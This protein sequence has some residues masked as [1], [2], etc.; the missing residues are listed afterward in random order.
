MKQI[1][2]LLTLVLSLSVT[3]QKKEKSTQLKSIDS[4]T[5][6]MVQKRGIIT[7]YLNE[8]N[9]LF[10]EMDESVLNKDLLV[11]T[12]IAQLPAN[13]SAYLNAGSKTAE[14]VLRFS[15]K[16]KKIILKQVGY[17]NIA[18]EGDPIAL[19]VA[20]NNF[21]PILAAFDIKNKE[22]DR[23]L[24]DVSSHFLADSPGFNII[25]KGDK[26]R[27][28][29]GS[30]DKKRSSI[31]S[32]NSFPKNTEVVHTLTFSVNKPPR[33]NRAKT[34]SFQINHSFIALPE[35]PMPIRYEDE[36]VGWF[37]LNKIN[38]SSDALKADDY[39]IV[40]RW[41]LEPKDKAA[42][43]AGELVEPIQP[44]VYYLD[45]ATP[46]KWRKYFKM[47]IEDWN[48][49]FAKAGFKNAI[50]AKDPPSKEEDPDFS[51]EDIRY[52]TVRY[53]ASTTRNATGPSVSDPRTGEILE[54]DI[55][56]YHNHLRS[57]RN[58]YLLETAAANPKA[59][60]LDTPE[61]EIGEMMRRVISHE[62]GHALGLPHNMKASSAY[63][64][65]SLRSGEFTQKYGIATT[66][67]D[68][69]R[70][71]YIAQPGDEYIRFVRQL[72][73]YDDYS[74]EWGYRYY[75]KSPEEEKKILSQFVDE[76][77][78]DPMYMFGG[79][80]ND[81][82]AQTENI[83]DDPIKASFYGLKNLKIV[84]RNLMDW[85]LQPNDDYT[86]LNELYGELTGVYR[87][88][89][90]HVHSIIGGVNKTQH[91]T[92]QQDVVTYKSVEKAKQIEA[93]AF[94]NTHV[95][96]TQAWLMQ[97]QLISEI[98]S[99]GI[100]LN[101]QNLQ[102]SAMT[103]LLATKNLNRL[104]STQNTLEGNG[105][106][107]NELLNILFNDIIKNVSKPDVSRQSLQIH[108]AHQIK[109][110]QEEEKLNPTIKASLVDLEC[111]LHKIAKRKARMNAG[112]LKKHY[113]Y[114]AE[115]TDD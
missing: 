12:R 51:P 30:V 109:I 14:Q 10:F 2:F 15:K 53:V 73:P 31:D 66:I 23:F 93:L 5:T 58:R 4:L 24:I 25:R 27:Y 92:N 71:N 37:S 101:L 88:Y 107:V 3:A 17:A 1:I 6:K 61:E 9:K 21:H 40:R 49:A 114:L 63:P 36:R 91:T 60:T 80:G 11:V 82:D 86:D 100:L 57:Y 20:E 18:D 89:I 103:R 75:D 104:L 106:T 22:E 46:L 79:R 33:T 44:I 70:Y 83:G 64:V 54:S 85:T 67:M 59:R 108:F 99:E 13:Y 65:D 90:N 68:Y 94:L 95:W 39:S 42:Y 81:P 78:L 98:K 19:S 69:A 34:F 16:G 45:P 26:E 77:S 62:I 38:Y 8:E 74:I 7:T 76:K 113:A 112:D 97:P 52:S 32:A 41:R 84:A 72:G 111:R 105:L 47:G 55:I 35:N 56:W 28:K 96:E 43:A 87:R 29:I 50:L 48:S 102:R 110:L 115:Q